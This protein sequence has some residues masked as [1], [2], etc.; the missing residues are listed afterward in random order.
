MYKLIVLP[1]ISINIIFVSVNCK[2]LSWGS[3]RNENLLL[4]DQFFY[5]RDNVNELKPKIFFYTSNGI[6]I[7][8]VHVND[9]TGNAGG[10]A[11]ILQGG[12]GYTFI[13]MKL[14]PNDHLLLLNVQI[15]GAYDKIYDYE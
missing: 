10:D 2:S 15:F 3:I 13:R 5:N 6:T 14:Y 7:S 12:V 1:L 8:A 11:S 4:F 9:L